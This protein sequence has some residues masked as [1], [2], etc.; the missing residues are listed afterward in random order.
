MEPLS[1]ASEEPAAANGA[2]TGLTWAPPAWAFFAAA[3]LAVGTVAHLGFSLNG[4]AWAVVQIV[5][6]FVAA[7]DLANRRIKNLVTVPVS[8]LAIVLRGAF[9]R[10]AFAEVV[11][12]GLVIFL[13]FFALSLFLRGGLG[14]GDVKLA[15]M[16][17]F[18]LGW[19]VLPALLVGT[20]AGGIAAFVLLAGGSRTRRA[21]LAYGPYLA[22][23]GM[24]AVLA[25]NPPDFF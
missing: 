12:A 3:A 24:I 5:L 10:S 1:T 25:A 15:G 7:Y 16:L 17:G 22:I 23:G 6:V 13:V 19:A 20:V 18:V 11:I 21:T 14:M 9:E 4:L 2:A 8:L